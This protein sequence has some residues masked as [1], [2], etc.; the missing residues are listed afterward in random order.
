MYCAAEFVQMYDFTG[1]QFVSCAQ[2]HAAECDKRMEKRDN[3]TR[4]NCMVYCAYRVQHL[5][6]ENTIKPKPYRDAAARRR[7]AAAPARNAN[8]EARA[9]AA[10]TEDF[11]LKY[12]SK[13]STFSRS[14]ARSI[15]IVPS[16]TSKYS[17]QLYFKVF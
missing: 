13:F 14:T 4:K 1:Q 12:R 6:I 10:R 11:L 16:G 3:F 5:I 15:S 17:V 2:C 9:R 8:G 7:R